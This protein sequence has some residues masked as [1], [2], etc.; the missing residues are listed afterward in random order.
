MTGTSVSRRWVVTISVPGVKRRSS[1]AID[2]TRNAER[3]Y[4]SIP[5]ATKS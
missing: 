3:E 5:K 2:R 1:G 4:A